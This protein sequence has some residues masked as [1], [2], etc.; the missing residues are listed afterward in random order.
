MSSSGWT[1]DPAHPP[2]FVLSGALGTL[3]PRSITPTI[4]N[5]REVLVVTGDDDESL[6]VRFVDLATGE[7]LPDRSLLHSADLVVLGPG[8]GRVLLATAT[9]RGTV[10]VRDAATGEPAG[11][12]VHGP[13]APH[14]LRVG[15]AGEREVVAV[16]GRIWDVTD[17]AEVTG[18]LPD[19]GTAGLPPGTGSLWHEGR[20][21]TATAG[22]AGALSV[23]GA[24]SPYY[25]GPVGSFGGWA[26]R[27]GRM[28]AILTGEPAMLYDIETGRPFARLP[29]P[30][31]DPENPV[32][33]ITGD[34]GFRVHDNVRDVDL[35][36]R[37]EPVTA[38]GY[39]EIDDLSL[40]VTGDADGVVR[41]WNVTSGEPVA[42]PWHGHPVPVTAAALTRWSGRIAA[43]TAD[44]SGTVRMWML[45]S[46][47]RRHAGHTDRV[48]AVAGGLRAGRPVFASGGDD[49]T[50]RFWD[51][52]T[53]APSGEPISTTPVT[54][55]TFA[56]DI[57][58][59]GHG[60]DLG[61]GIQRW[62][63]VTGEPSGSPLPGSGRPASAA[64]DDRFL[65]AAVDGTMLRVWDAA[66]GAPHTT[67]PLPEPARL[68]DLAVH[69][70][71]LLAL[72]VSGPEY[73][74]GQTITIWDVLAARPLRPPTVT[75]DDGG[76][77]A[78]GLVDGRLTV[79]HGV[80]AG[81]NAATAGLWPEAAGD[82]HVRDVAT[83]E[84]GP[85]FRP[86]SGWNQQLALIDGLVLVAAD[87]AVLTWD[88]TTGGAAAPPVRTG[89]GQFTCVTAIEA[90]GHLFAAAGD[91]A[92][93]VR[94][95]ALE[96]PR[97]RRP[98]G[99]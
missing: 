32:E 39:R 43:V 57:L 12:A 5:G 44:A 37:E 53:G 69:D 75:A 94:I 42:G 99:A 63:P 1:T 38:T 45:D 17:G 31:F 15:L 97:R 62:D 79:A 9:A 41:V 89:T 71:R 54:G 61:A 52:V 87:D 47:L 30:D 3:R 18:H 19:P 85:G 35:L 65:M 33:V 58:V 83:G 6:P 76:H 84:P 74:D 51:P 29:L 7:P 2:H 59:S 95:W 21:L 36:R 11:P 67:M 34:S 8:R 4:A 23:S 16:G 91:W 72:T 40:L 68:Q 56:G 49:G 70:G 73:G 86:D 20:L 81:E 27:S 92:G 60:T 25:G 77:G 80:D 50:I 14:D 13:A 78:F 55:V 98:Q 66:T 26:Q 48:T 46:P 10:V 22:R 88:A 93:T 96:A 64:W 28:L 82:I 90:K 24:R